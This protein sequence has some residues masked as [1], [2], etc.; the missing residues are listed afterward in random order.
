MTRPSA[1][2]GG[3]DRLPKMAS[4]RG[5]DGSSEIA[6]AVFLALTAVSPWDRLSTLGAPDAV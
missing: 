1:I 3:R 6:P 2:S 4:R 5:T